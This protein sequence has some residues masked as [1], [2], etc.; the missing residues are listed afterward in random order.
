ML[1]TV[2]PYPL[3][4]Y[5]QQ[6]YL[7][8]INASQSTIWKFESLKRKLYN[9]NTSIHFNRQCLKKNLTPSYAQIKVPNTSPARARTHARTHTQRKVTS[10]RIRDEIKYL[11][12]KKQKLNTLMYQMHL[13][14]AN[15]WDNLWP[16]IY[17]ISQPIRCI[18]S[19]EKCDLNSTCILC[20]EGN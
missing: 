15:T 10:I 1:L 11:Y 12:C 7:K 2:L 3:F 6:G 14:L 20:V 16:H 5:T 8:V 19:P 9:C 4:L 17:R 13:T 18:F